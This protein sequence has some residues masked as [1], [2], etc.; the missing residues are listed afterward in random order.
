MITFHASIHN[1]KI[2]HEGEAKLTLV[3]P[4]SELSESIRTVMNL[5]QLLKVTIQATNGD[6]HA[7]TETDQVE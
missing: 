5:N 4:S 7:E 2:D 3:I 6:S 1:I